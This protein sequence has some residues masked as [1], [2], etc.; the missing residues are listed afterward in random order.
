MEFTIKKVANMVFIVSDCGTIFKT[1]KDSEF[2]ERKL[3]NV[4]K[5]IS[6]NCNGNVTF[7]RKF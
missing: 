1:W 5:K 3:N 2:T 6:E 4:I 7:G